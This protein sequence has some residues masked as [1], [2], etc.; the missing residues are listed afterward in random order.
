MLEKFKSLLYEERYSIEGAKKILNREIKS[1]FE[2]ILL[3]KDIRDI[4]KN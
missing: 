1:E 4:V 3:I 2:K